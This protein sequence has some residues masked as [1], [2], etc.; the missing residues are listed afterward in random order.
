MNN[1]KTRKINLSIKFI[2]LFVIM[3]ILFLPVNGLSVQI[4][5]MKVIKTGTPH[6]L[7]DDPHLLGMLLK[8]DVEGL[9]R[10][11]RQHQYKVLRPVIIR[12]TFSC[13]NNPK[14]LLNL[15]VETYQG[16]NK[17]GEWVTETDISKDQ[18]QKK[19][20]E[21]T[22]TEKIER[23]FRQDEIKRREETDRVNRKYRQE[24]D[25][26]RDRLNPPQEEEKPGNSVLINNN[27]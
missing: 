1:M 13:D 20:G 17:W 2:L 10:H 4:K 3:I 9:E 8:G 25:D 27:K 5:S 23:K 15:D 18:L 11:E 24:T 22:H 7:E 12:V 21:E 6:Y 26:L 16:K 19:C 14:K